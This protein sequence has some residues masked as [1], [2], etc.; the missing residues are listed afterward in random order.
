[1]DPKEGGGRRPPPSFGSGRRPRPY[2]CFK[3]RSKICLRYIFLI[4]F[5]L[6]G[7]PGVYI[8]GIFL[9]SSRILDFV[10]FSYILGICPGPL[11][12]IDFVFLLYFPGF[13][14]IPQCYGDTAMQDLSQLVASRLDLSGLVWSPVALRAVPWVPISKDL[15]A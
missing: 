15:Q 14:E 10:Y 12:I 6:G 11:Q 4:Y 9:G 2:I 1:M 5:E 3:N 7:P 8:L 13:P